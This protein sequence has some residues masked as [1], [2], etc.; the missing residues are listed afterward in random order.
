MQ[1]IQSGIREWCVSG[2]K[3]CC[4]SSNRFGWQEQN[5]MYNETLYNTTMHQDRPCTMATGL[6][7]GDFED[8]LSVVLL[9]CGELCMYAKSP[10][11]L[12]P[13][14]SSYSTP[15]FFLP[16]WEPNEQLLLRAPVLYKK[17]EGTLFVTPRR[18]AWQQ[19]GTPQLNPS[20]LYN[21]ISGKILTW[22]EYS[23]IKQDMNQT[24][25]D[26]RFTT[27]TWKS[28]QSPAQD[29]DNSGSCTQRLHVPVH[30][31]K[32][33]DRTRSC[34]VPNYRVIGTSKRRIKTIASYTSSFTC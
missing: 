30:I 4:V 2:R 32:G 21:S 33:I 26:S 1:M 17:N 31:A 27:D 19:Q 22:T 12:Y 8:R 18:I 20:I 14:L 9:H 7:S 23:S 28:S 10:H 3:G 5:D 11:R 16:M 13:F 24:I 15:F 29:L 25:Y 6:S 34:K